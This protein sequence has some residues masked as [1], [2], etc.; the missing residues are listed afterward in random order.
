MSPVRAVSCYVCWSATATL[1]RRIPICFGCIRSLGL[2]R[3]PPAGPG[4]AGS[5]MSPSEQT[6]QWVRFNQGT[7]QEA[8]RWHPEAS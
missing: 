4:S 3:P 2:S 6:I 5:E 8:V 1:V 7:T